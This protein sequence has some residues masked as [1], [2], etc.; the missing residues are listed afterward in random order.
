M[1]SADQG[2]PALG[3]Q[4][5]GDVALGVLLLESAR[6]AVEALEL[7]ARGIVNVWHAGTLACA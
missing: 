5:R 2:R 6:L 1:A 7:L 4:G 3:R